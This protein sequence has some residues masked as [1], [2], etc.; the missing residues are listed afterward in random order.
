MASHQLDYEILGAH[1]QSVEIILDPGETVIAEAGAMNYMTEGVRFETRMGDGSESGVL[2]KLWGMGKRMLT[3]E[4]LFMTHFSNHGKRQARV[5]FAAPYPGTVVPVDLAEIGGTLICQKDSFLCAAR[6]TEIG[7]S[8][9][10]RIGAGFFGGEGFILQRLSGDGLAFLH[11]GG[12]VIRK[13]LRD[14]TLRLDTGCLVGF[15]RGIDYDIQL[16]GGLKSMLFGGE[17][18]LLATL[19]GT[20]TVWLQSLPFSRLAERVYESTVKAR[21]DVRGGGD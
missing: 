13:E 9:S 1:A 10:K 18:I 3:G 16:A 2:G 21:E 4:S 14:E 7:I 19:K 11:A 8:F 17:G 6:G 20:G 5:A 15:S 12:A